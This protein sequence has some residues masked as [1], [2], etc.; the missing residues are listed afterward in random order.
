[1]WCGVV[2]ELT[3]LG[4]SRCCGRRRRNSEVLLLQTAHNFP[5]SSTTWGN[6]RSSCLGLFFLIIIILVL[7]L[8]QHVTF[9]QSVRSASAERERAPVPASP[10]CAALCQCVRLRVSDPESC[11]SQRPVIFSATRDSIRSHGARARFTPPLMHAL[12][13]RKWVFHRSFLPNSGE[14][15]HTWQL[16]KP[17]APLCKR[18]ELLQPS[19]FVQ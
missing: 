15:L 3:W 5:H 14:I 6:K 10:H 12:G 19:C 17:S 16:R 13:N 2:W 18:N 7:F 1:M 8:F 11:L 4:C 9:S